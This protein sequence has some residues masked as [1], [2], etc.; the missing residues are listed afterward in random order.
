[1]EA[2]KRGPDS[3]EDCKYNTKPWDFRLMHKTIQSM[4]R[5]EAAAKGQRFAA[6]LFEWQACLPKP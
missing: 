3:P 2:Q 1:M 4:R 6:I 5:C